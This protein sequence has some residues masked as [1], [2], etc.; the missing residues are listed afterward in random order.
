[1]ITVNCAN[2]GKDVELDLERYDDHLDEEVV[3]SECAW[4]ASLFCF[5]YVKGNPKEE[6]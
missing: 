6:G 4:S 5:D 3:C 1:M 2:C